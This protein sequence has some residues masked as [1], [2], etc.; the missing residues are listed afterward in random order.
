MRGGD[1]F[2]MMIVLALIGFGLI[3]WWWDLDILF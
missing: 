3:V 1:S 2:V